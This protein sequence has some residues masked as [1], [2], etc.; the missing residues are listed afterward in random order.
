MSRSFNQPQS[1]NSV[2]SRNNNLPYCWYSFS[3]AFKE[4]LAE[5]T[6]VSPLFYY[7]MDV[8]LPTN[9]W[10][11]RRIFRY[12]FY[13]FTYVICYL[14]PYPTIAAAINIEDQKKVKKI[15]LE[16]FHVEYD[17]FMDPMV[18]AVRVSSNNPLA[19]LTLL[20]ICLG[21]ILALG[22]TIVCCG[23]IWYIIRTKTIIMSERNRRN[24]RT[25]FTSLLSLVLVLINE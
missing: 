24:Q 21:C 25:L 6:S 20:L 15:L 3:H 14:L 22:V 13:F 4:V 7:R 18:I 5:A 9:N 2:S 1:F 16:T 12:T 17:N 8:I 11:N 19:I 23:I 10:L